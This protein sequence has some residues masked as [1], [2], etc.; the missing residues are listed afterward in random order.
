MGGIHIRLVI[1]GL[2]GVLLLSIV[3]RRWFGPEGVL[4]R[5]PS[6]GDLDLSSPGT[7][8]LSP[9]RHEV[10]SSA[11]AA[12]DNASWY[13]LDSALDPQWKVRVDRFMSSVRVSRFSVSRGPRLAHC[14]FNDSRDVLLHGNA[15]PSHGGGCSTPQTVEGIEAPMEVL[16]CVRDWLHRAL[17][18]ELGVVDD[19]P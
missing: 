9:Q 4:K 13:R 8:A 17:L 12:P 19:T 3:S 5:S 2:V 7:S 15:A 16:V 18:Y 6:P 10:T 1:I 11:F 14:V